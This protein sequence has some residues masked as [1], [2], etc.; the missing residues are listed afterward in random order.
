MVDDDENIRLLVR[1]SLDKTKF[2]VIQARSAK[3]ELPLV[4][5]TEIDCIIMDLNMPEV[6]GFPNHFRNSK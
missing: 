4:L 1:L 3:E 2:I 6:D 5:K